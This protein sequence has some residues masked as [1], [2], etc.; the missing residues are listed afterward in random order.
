MIGYN[1]DSSLQ[2]EYKKGLQAGR[3]EVIAALLD[4]MDDPTRQ[5]GTDGREA[6]R[7]LARQLCEE[8][9]AED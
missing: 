2:A 9:P 8:F 1:I 3:D 4:R 5:W 7:E 6:I